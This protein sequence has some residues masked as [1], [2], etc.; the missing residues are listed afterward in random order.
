MQTRQTDFMTLVK[1]SRD[2]QQKH[3][4]VRRGQMPSS[5]GLKSDEA[6]SAA[7]EAG[8]GAVVGAT[9]V[10]NSISPC[11]IREL[12]DVSSGVLQLQF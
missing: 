8:R 9:K 6:N 3:T 1:V 4:D 11:G 10:C 7:W 12:M 2:L 5:G